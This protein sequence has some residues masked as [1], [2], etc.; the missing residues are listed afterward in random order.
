M[1]TQTR[2]DLNAA[3]AN[4]QQELV[5]QPDLTPAV[6]RELETHLRDTIAELQGRGLNNEESFWLARRRTGKPEQ[7]GEE[8]AKG[9]PSEIWRERLFWIALAL[10]AIEVWHATI[11]TLYLLVNNL[12]TFTSQNIYIP[13][14]LF[15]V[16]WLPIAAGAIFAVKGRLPLRHRIAMFKSPIKLAIAGFSWIAV[17]A[18]VYG[19][20]LRPVFNSARLAMHHMDVLYNLL[21]TA[22]AIVVWPASLLTFL[23]WLM[24]SRSPSRLKPS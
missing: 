16:N 2:F 1:E 23:I 10:F 19:T 6:R 18:I 5:A 24:R 12:E 22:F 3:I 21:V 9:D 4:W 15:V 17:V 13:I 20:Q 14:V 11:R 8:F 7:L